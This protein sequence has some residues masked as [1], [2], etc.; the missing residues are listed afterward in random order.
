MT[1]Y[2]Y[3]VTY[4]ADEV[5]SPEELRK[6]LSLFGKV[7]YISRSVYGICSDTEWN[8]EFMFS[9]LKRYIHQPAKNLFI[10]YLS[11]YFPHFD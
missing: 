1:S 8:V 11:S 10:A 4:D 2:R 5:S 9:E 7:T 6:K 3:L